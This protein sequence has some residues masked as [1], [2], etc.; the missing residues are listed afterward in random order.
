MTLLESG[1]GYRIFELT[2]NSTQNFKMRINIMLPFN[3][4]LVFRALN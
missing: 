3:K 1:Q 4:S 2:S